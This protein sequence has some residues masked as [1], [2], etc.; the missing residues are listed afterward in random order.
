MH[1]LIAKVICIANVAIMC[2]SLCFDF[3]LTVFSI[4]LSLG[5]NLQ[6]QNAVSRVIVF[7]KFRDKAIA[8]R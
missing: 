1:D 8:K 3:N 7:I 4:L 2:I 6:L 5:I